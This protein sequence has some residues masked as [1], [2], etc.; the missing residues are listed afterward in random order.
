M[1]ASFVRSSM[2]P[3]FDRICALSAVLSMLASVNFARAAIED[4]PVP[5]GA[6]SIVIPSGLPPA[7]R[8]EMRDTALPGEPFDSIDV[9]VKGHKHSRFLFVWNIGTRWIVAV[10]RGG[11]AL[12]SNVYVYNLGKDDKVTRIKEIVTFPQSAC[13]VATKL[14]QK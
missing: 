13:A 7:L 6:L 5:T 10:E 11:I 9:Y 4:C 2:R 8:D 14:V 12:R 1:L 3:L